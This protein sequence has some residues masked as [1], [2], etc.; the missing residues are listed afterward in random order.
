[1]I[2]TIIFLLLLIP[3]GS[4]LSENLRVSGQIDAWH[5]GAI[6][7]RASGTGTMEYAAEG[8]LG[9]FSSGFNLS[10]GQGSYSF[11][12]DDYSLQISDF[13]GSAIGESDSASTTAD[14]NGTGTLKTKS[15]DNSRRGVLMLGMQSGEINAR[16]IILGF[17]ASTGRAIDNASPDLMDTNATEGEPVGNVTAFQINS[18]MEFSI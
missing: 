10:N 16:G 6:S 2:K 12:A 8:Y 5:D 9:G 4:A 11:K 18:S 17:H 1:M 14:V 3:I 7:D 15:Y 13:S